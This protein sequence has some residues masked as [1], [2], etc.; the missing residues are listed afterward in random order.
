MLVVGREKA[1]NL[2]VLFQSDHN[3]QIGLGTSIASLL[4]NNQHLDNITIYLIDNGIEEAFLNVLRQYVF[5]F[6][7]KINIIPASHLLQNEL[8][9]QYPCYKGKRKNKNSYLKLFWQFGIEEKIDK[10][11]YIDC[12][13]VIDNDLASLVGLDMGDKPIGM[14]YDALITDEIEHI[15]LNPDDHYFNSGVILF[16]AQK[17]IED[18]CPYRI[19]QH[20]KGKNRSYGTVDQDVLNLVFRNQIYTLPMRYN[21]QPI[22]FLMSAFD[23]LHEFRR[24]NYYDLDEIQI[25]ENEI[26]IVHFVKFLGQNVWDKGNLNPGKKY[27]EKYAKQMPWKQEIA[28]THLAPIFRIEKLLYRI[29]PRYLFLKIFHYAHRLMI[30]KAMLKEYHDNR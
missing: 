21:F 12:D 7:R 18:Q 29:L 5:S 30:K 20:F 17:W 26:C 28:E 24:K 11:L 8:V 6:Q 2:N 25:T 14:V 22:H 9:K 15:G 13:T 3:T 19:I 10:L 23:Y 4:I 1:N 27:F 16:N